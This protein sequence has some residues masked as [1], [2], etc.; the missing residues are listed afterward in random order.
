M[1]GVGGKILKF[2]LFIVVLVVIVRYSLSHDM[3]FGSAVVAALIVS[4][5]A[6]IMMT[7]FGLVL[8]L[9]GN[10]VIAI[11]VSLG[12]MFFGLFKLDE[13]AKY[14]SWMTD[15]ISA[16]LL[17]LVAFILMARDILIIIGSMRNSGGGNTGPGQ[18]S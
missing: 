8:V 1:S 9:S 11:I 6:Y 16:V 18:S 15:D 2:I 17:C 14:I 13:I 10:Y 4:C 12:V 5:F 3:S 7:L